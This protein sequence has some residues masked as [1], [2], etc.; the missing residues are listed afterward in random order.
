VAG[1][2]TQV[3]FWMRFVSSWWTWWAF[4]AG[5][6]RPEAITD[7]WRRPTRRRAASE[8]NSPAGRKRPTRST[9]RSQLFFQ[10]GINIGGPHSEEVH[11]RSRRSIER[12]A[13]ELPSCRTGKCGGPAWPGRQT[14]RES[15]RPV[16][17]EQGL[18]S[19]PVEPV[20]GGGSTDGEGR[21]GRVAAPKGRGPAVMRLR[22][23]VG[24][25]AECCKL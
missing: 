13:S 1:P 24:V 18:D 2:S 25:S 15:G 17:N 20:V 14:A 8:P 10:Q 11:Q 16:A 5:P 3:L 19:R 6:E 22:T 4:W 23:C 9:R 21:S 7:V 12:V